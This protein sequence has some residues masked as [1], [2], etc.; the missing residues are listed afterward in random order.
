MQ[1]SYSYNTP[2][3]AAGGIVD[4]APHY[5]RSFTNEADTGAVLF[6]MGVVTGAA[7]GSG[8]TVPAAGDTAAKFEGVVTNRRTTELDLEGN[9]TLRNKCALGVMQYGTIYALVAEG[10][11][12]AYGDAAYLLVSGD[13][14][15]FFT[16]ASGE[17]AVAIKGRFLSTV[18]NGIA[19]LELFNQAQV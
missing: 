4:L 9:L 8:V 2:I 11:E 14:A 7:A 10:I 17:G 15:G 12:P 6:G 18:E 16:N 3:G 19:I 13:N 5:I 1:T